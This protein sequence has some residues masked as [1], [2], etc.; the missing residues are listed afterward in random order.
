MTH[1]YSL[2]LGDGIMAAMPSVEIEERFQRVYLSAGKPPEMAVFLR[3]ESEGRLHCEVIAYF[4]PAASQVAKAFDAQPC[5]KPAR[6]G[7]SLLTGDEQAWAV[8]FHE[9]TP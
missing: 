4:S 8:L 3:S 2:S 6:P 5:V 1:W 9:S 7:L